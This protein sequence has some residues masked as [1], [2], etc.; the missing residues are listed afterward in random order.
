MYL[1]V[2]LDNTQT[3]ASEAA[4]LHFMEKLQ[5]I[6]IL[7]VAAAIAVFIAS[8]SV[9]QPASACPNCGVVASVKA[10]KQQP[11]TSVVGMVGGGVVGALAG[12]AIGDGNTLATLGGAA[13][14]AYLGNKVG[15][16][17]QSGTRYK[18]VVR[19]D[20]GGTRSISYR[21][22]PQFAVGSHVRLENGRLLPA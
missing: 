20:G 22:R 13:G 19:M 21:Q 11:K 18:V 12:N 6:R 10:Y 1:A 5:K 4:T 17:V 8:P 7:L 14:G 16:K 3:P 2:G 15:Q 9:A